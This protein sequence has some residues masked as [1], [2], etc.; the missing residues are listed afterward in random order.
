VDDCLKKNPDDRPTHKELLDPPS[1]EQNSS[2][3]VKLQLQIWP[4]LSI[5]SMIGFGRN[6]GKI[7]YFIL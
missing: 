3:Q 4:K 2:N 5:G 7:T 1:L 6:N